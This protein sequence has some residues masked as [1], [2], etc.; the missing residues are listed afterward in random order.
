MHTSNLPDRCTPTSGFLNTI[1][2]AFDTCLPTPLTLTST[3][4]GI[5]SIIAWLFAQLPQVFKNYKLQSASGLSIYFLAE[6]LLGDA[7][8]LIGA[9]LTQQ[10]AWQVIVASYYVTVDVALVY[11]Y[12]WYSHV[13]P[14]R[15]KHLGDDVYI[16]DEEE[17][18]G[19]GGVLVGESPQG[20]SI[21][22]SAPEVEGKKVKT[23]T[24][25]QPAKPSS[26]RSSNFSFSPKEKTM[27]SS[28]RRT[29]CSGRNTASSFEP[30]PKSLLL[31]TVLCAVV[32]RASPLHVAED[33][34]VAL[35]S[36]SNVELIGRI[37]SWIS[38]CAYLGSRLPQIYKNARRRSTAG[39]S[40]ALFIAA[41]FGNLFYSSSMLTSPLAW[42]SYPPYGLHGWVGSEGSD[43]ATWVSLAA[44]F[45][46]G[47]AG[48]LVMD[49]IVG[50]QFL[51]FG[52]G[53]K[54]FIVKD[55]RGRSRWSKV[56]GWMRGWI[57]SPS[58]QRAEI[59][60]DE[61]LLSATDGRSH[62]GYGAA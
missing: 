43:R 9:L 24:N 37:S 26:F 17:N 1:S 54:A 60:E 46:L 14:W 20:T 5:L 3:L 50:A 51:I 25:P 40:P 23:N 10:A 16:H 58:P 21:S 32:T 57:P 39:L 47:A 59:R 42:A 4:F 7:T 2:T 41:F 12:I 13:K 44:P 48:V 35:T 55:G 61:G 45:W 19:P 31:I 6:W 27:A 11:Q 18:N 15:K 28:P 22:S 62:E 33:T 36:T 30:S 34:G 56:S 38:T 53:E 52:D 8:N 29:I 49:A